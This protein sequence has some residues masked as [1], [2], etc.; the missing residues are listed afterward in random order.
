MQDSKRET[1]Q[2]RKNERSA[3]N[4]SKATAKRLMVLPVDSNEEDL[5]LLAHLHVLVTDIDI[6]SD[7]LQKT[8]NLLE[9]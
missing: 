7:M 5:L 4:R 8:H 3:Q 6:F 2:K 1:T 9:T